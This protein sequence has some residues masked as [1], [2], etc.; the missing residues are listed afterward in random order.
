MC[1][2]YGRVS[3]AGAFS[4]KGLWEPSVAALRDGRSKTRA[5]E[6]T[7]MRFIEGMSVRRTCL[8]AEGRVPCFVDCIQD[9]YQASEVGLSNESS[10]TQAEVPMHHYPTRGFIDMQHLPHGQDQASR[11]SATMANAQC[12]SC[13]HLLGVTCQLSAAE[14]TSPV[15]WPCIARVSEQG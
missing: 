11:S 10:S 9:F 13:R 7:N 4:Q 5:K 8:T 14:V 6:S 3:V 2:T 1:K 12:R 15:L